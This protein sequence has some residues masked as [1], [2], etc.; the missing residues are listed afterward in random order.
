MTFE[1]LFLTIF[2]LEKI[3]FGAFLCSFAS[4]SIIHEMCLIIHQ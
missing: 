1:G 2:S 4:K 3:V